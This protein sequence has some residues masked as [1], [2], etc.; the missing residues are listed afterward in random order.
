MYGCSFGLS[1]FCITAWTGAASLFVV[2]TLL[3]VRSSEL[4]ST[5][6]SILATLRFPAYYL[7]AFAL[8]TP[9]LVVD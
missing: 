5:T 6:K 7:F 2:A 1:R 9:A 8:V 4:D 3:E